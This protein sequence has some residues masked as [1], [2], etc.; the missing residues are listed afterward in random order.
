MLTYLIVDDE[1]L[2]LK[3]MER[4]LKELVPAGSQILTC[5][6]P[7]DAIALAGTVSI[8]VAFLDI[9]MPQ[10]S[11]IDCAK[12]LQA[13]S[14]DINIIFTT[15]YDEYMVNAWNLF[16]SGYLL[17]PVMQS[18]LKNALSH[19]RYPIELP[20][21]KLTVRCFGNFE[22]FFNGQPV[23][24]SRTQSKEFLAYLVDR[25][26]VMVEQNEL[27]SIL[28]EAE[29]DTEQKKSYIR[30]IASDLRSSFAKLGLEDVLMHQRGR[31]GINTQ[32]ISCDFYSYLDGD[33]D[34]IRGYNHE[35]MK[36]YA[37]AQS[38]RDTLEENFA[39]KQ[40]LL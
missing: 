35:Y 40:P 25:R 22:C 33:I 36:Q 2:I 5:T 39:R 1:P 32:A 10:M 8:Q 13:I 27:R 4:Q 7:V 29:K 20:G 12:Q 30:S 23:L 31:Y 26:G 24:F 18:D 28:W 37:W 3:D 11:G 38:T 6:N 14:S 17:K 19:L 9:S 15:A 16:A 21:S 34:A